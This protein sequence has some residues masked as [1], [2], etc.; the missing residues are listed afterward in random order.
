[1]PRSATP[2]VLLALLAIG[3]AIAAGLAGQNAA[4]PAP[5]ADRGA[6]ARREDARQLNLRGDPRPS[7]PRP[8]GRGRDRV[9][10]GGPH[11]DAG[12]LPRIVGAPDRA[13]R[14]P[15]QARS[16]ARLR[17]ARRDPDVSAPAA[18]VLV[19]LE[20]ETV[21]AGQT[22]AGPTVNQ[23]DLR[24]SSGRWRV[25]AFTAIPGGATPGIGA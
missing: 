15:L 18:R 19:T 13:R 12:E 20:E 4:A 6:A 3:V 16:E 22:I 2:L 5:D 7:E 1:M 11:L 21:A 25:V 17:D 24:R 9:R 10:A 14:R 23:I 8:A